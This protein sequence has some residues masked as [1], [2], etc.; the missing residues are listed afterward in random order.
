MP[1][2][3]LLYGVL[4]DNK[5]RGLN[6]APRDRS[7]LAS[8]EAAT[9]DCSMSTRE[10]HASIHEQ[11]RGKIR[12]VHK[13]WQDLPRKVHRQDFLVTMNRND[14]GSKSARSISLSRLRHSKRASACQV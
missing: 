2:T 3:G 10:R 9:A 5:K 7:W 12:Q 11:E 4:L 1:M 13:R 14:S 8:E 6:E